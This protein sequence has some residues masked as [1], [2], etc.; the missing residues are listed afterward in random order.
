VWRGMCW[1]RLG[2]GAKAQLNSRKALDADPQNRAAR[3]RLRG[4]DG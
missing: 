1:E 3:Q 2:N 4:L